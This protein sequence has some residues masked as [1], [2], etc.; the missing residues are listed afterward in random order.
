LSKHAVTTVDGKR[1]RVGDVVHV[2]IREISS[3]YPMGVGPYPAIVT[4]LLPD[5]KIDASGFPID[6]CGALGRLP[7]TDGKGNHDVHEWWEFMPE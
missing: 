5:D 3:F 2:F 6:V 4:I 7:Y 1:L